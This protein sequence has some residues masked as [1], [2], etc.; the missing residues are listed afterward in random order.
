MNKTI[1]FIL[2]LIF[3]FQKLRIKFS[4]IEKPLSIKIPNNAVPKAVAKTIRAVDFSNK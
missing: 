3:S 2:S 1:F 4:T